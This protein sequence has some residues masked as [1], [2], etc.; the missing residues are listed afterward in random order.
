MLSSQLT[1]AAKIRSQTGA[2]AAAVISWLLYAMLGTACPTC[3]ALLKSCGYREANQNTPSNTTAAA[4]MMI[5][6]Q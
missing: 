2:S 4:T 3:S 6:R 1:V 5:G